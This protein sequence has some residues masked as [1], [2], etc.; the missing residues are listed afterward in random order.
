MGEVVLRIVE[1]LG[2]IGASTVVY[3]WWQNMGYSI[4][5]IG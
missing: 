1:I 4:P 2:V 3:A 5:F